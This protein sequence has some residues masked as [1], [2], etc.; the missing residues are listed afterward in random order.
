MSKR[1][2][3]I[4]LDTDRQPSAFD[5]VVAVDAGVD[6]LLPYGG[7]TPET[8]RPLIYGAIFTRGA[9]DLKSTALF[10][11]GSAVAEGEALLA[12]IRQ[13]FF[14]PMRVSVLLDSNGAN[15]TAAAAVLAALKHLN[16]PSTTALVLGATGPVGRRVVRLLAAEGA[17]VRAGSRNLRRAEGVIGELT[18]LA[19]RVDAVSTRD[20][21]E[22]AAALEGCQ[23]VIAAGAAG[24]KLLSASTWQAADELR[25]LVDLN[26]VPPLGIEGVEATDRDTER[27]GK[28]AYGALGVGGAKMKVHKAALARLF[29]RNDLVL[30]AEEVL[31]IGRKALMG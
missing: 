30:D 5:S 20:D 3:L 26:A 25:V 1:R 14:G 13:T 6:V 24:A 27:E 2:V 15:T 31:A 28:H 10:I 7:V 18:T 17:Q 8:V 21:A 12:E 4:Q 11:G 22:T 9:D 19:G 23:L 16:L 29:E